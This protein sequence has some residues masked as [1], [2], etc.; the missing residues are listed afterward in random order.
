MRETEWEVGQ[1]LLRR[2]SRTRTQQFGG[3]MSESFDHLGK[4]ASIA[5]TGAAERIGPGVEATREAAVKGWES[6][7]AAM[8]PVVAAAVDSARARAADAEK[9]ARK[10]GRSAKQTARQRADSAAV[11][12]RL[13]E[14][15]KSH[16]GR[17][18]FGALAVG[19]AAGV[20][21]ALVA[22]RRTPQWEEYA[23]ERTLGEVTT[24]DTSL[25]TK[26]AQGV[27]AAK[28]K[29]A[30]GVDKA[31]E[32]IGR[33]VDTGADT[34][35][36]GVDSAAAAAKDATDKAAA[37]AKRGVNESRPGQSGTSGS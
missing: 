35:K 33:G 19:A 29:L 2:D 31:R 36:Q 23:P 3:E 21:G 20:A 34:A 22:R 4:A 10:A 24:E 27:D 37:N 30:Q 9:T 18:L 25:R 7:V 15:P 17:W 8:A 16:K 11:A 32:R 28:G 5:A 13:K 12:L 26:A 6:M 14:P 1:V